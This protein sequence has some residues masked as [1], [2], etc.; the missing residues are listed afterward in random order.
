MFGGRDKKLHCV[1]RATGKK[2]WWFPTKRKV[3]GS[4]VIVGDKVD[5]MATSRNSGGGSS[6]SR[7]DGAQRSLKSG[8]RIAFGR[9]GR[10]QASP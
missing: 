8:Q 9:S 7:T 2:L 3:D 4:P 5:H 6:P 1:D 10:V